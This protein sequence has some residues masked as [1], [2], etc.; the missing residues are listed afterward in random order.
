M[1]TLTECQITIK[2]GDASNI[3]CIVEVTGTPD[4]VAYAA[5]LIK[6]VLGSGDAVM[7]T[8][9]S[10]LPGNQL[11]YNEQ[12]Q[13]QNQNN[14]IRETSTN[15]TSPSLPPKYLE[16]STHRSISKLELGTTIQKYASSSTNTDQVDGNIDH[17]NQPFQGNESIESNKL[18]TSPQLI[19]NNNNDNN[20]DD[21]NNNHH[22]NNNDDNDNINNHN[23]ENNNDNNN[24]NILPSTVENVEDTYVS[25]DDDDDEDNNNNNNNNNNQLKS[26]KSNPKSTIT[27]TKYNISPPPSPPPSTIYPEYFIR[28]QSSKL[29]ETV[30]YPIGKF[31]D[32]ELEEISLFSRCKIS[33]L[34]KNYNQRPDQITLQF[35]GHPDQ[36]ELAKLL[37]DA[38]VKP[39]Q[40]RSPGLS[41]KDGLDGVVRTMDCPP[42][43]IPMLI[44]PGG[45][46]I[47]SIQTQSGTKI[48]INENIDEV[49]IYHYIISL[50]FY[51]F[52]I[53]LNYILTYF[54]F[55]RIVL[56]HYQFYSQ[57]KILF[58]IS[59][60]I[61]SYSIDLSELSLH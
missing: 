61:S 25:S 43:F 8:V 49:I 3:Y 14:E 29:I 26:P 15:I 48:L 40:Y 28:S 59:S 4:K 5:P 46:T 54:D 39:G 47:E 12:D 60:L 57:I 6:M 10:I 2:K 9:R 32:A 31:S 17:L 56:Q 13:L 22:N 51:Y 41:Q 33:P 11:Q 38:I 35:Q 53:I 45:M 44:G 36:R 27:P 7:T 30:T 37:M 24:N 18:R 34:E 16:N 19:S 58:L 50:Y 42:H 1:R 20:N 52:I 23:N 55:F 21:E